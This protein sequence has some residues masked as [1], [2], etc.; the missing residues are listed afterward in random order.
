MEIRFILFP[1]TRDLKEDNTNKVA[2]QNRNRDRD[3]ESAFRRRRKKGGFDALSLF[4]SLSLAIFFAALLLFTR[5]DD[6]DAFYSDVSDAFTRKHETKR[7]GEKLSFRV[8]NPNF[9]KLFFRLFFFSLF[10]SKGKSVASCAR[11]V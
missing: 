11:F 5:F 3:R 9:E 1:S 2:L 4:S 10:A 7:L 6:D 8:S